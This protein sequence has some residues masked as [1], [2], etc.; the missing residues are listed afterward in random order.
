[1][2][3]LYRIPR[4]F[5]FTIVFSAAV[6]AQ[7]ANP[8]SA[9]LKEGYKLVWADEFNGA[10][11]PDTLSWNHERGFARNQE[12][13][14]YQPDN[15]WC[16]NGRLI[17][18]AR[19][20]TKPN[21]RYKKDGKDWRDSREYIQYTSSSINTS[22][23][24]SW[25][26][27]RFVM[28]GKIDVSAGLWPAWWTLGVSGE[29]P[30]NGEIDIMEYYKGRILANIAVGTSKRYQAEWHSKTKAVDEL[31]GA[32]W[33][34]EFHIWRMDWTETEISLFVDDQLLIA[35]AMDQLYNKDGSS[36]HPFKQP[37]YMLLD[38]AM[39]GL[40]GGVLGD[41]KFPNRFEVDYVSV[42]QK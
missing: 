34:S 40:N 12:L 33:A 4:V 22:G 19:K 11:R 24:H 29:W 27:G 6:Y 25:Q 7:K 35:V 2:N 10:G 28:R 31:G 8:S 13:Q 15:A 30:S 3:I 41:T 5:F 17:I 37:H 26:Y 1:M 18:E 16:E 32:A 14:W 38:L 20:E 36:T 9:Y 23:L 42:Y 39:G 21:P